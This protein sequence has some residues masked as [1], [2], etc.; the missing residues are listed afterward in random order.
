MKKKLLLLIWFFLTSS[1]SFAWTYPLKYVSKP[2]ASCKFSPWSSLWPDC[3]IPLPKLVPSDYKK[4]LNNLTYR[5]IYTVLRWASYKYWWDQWYGSHE[6]VDIATSLGTPVY[7]IGPGKVVYAGYKKGWW[8]VIVIQHRLNWRYIYSDYAHLSKI[9]VKFW[10][11]VKEWQKIGEVGHTG[12]SI[13]NHL[14]FEID[15]NQSISHHPFW[16]WSCA[17]WRRIISITNDNKCFPELERNTID[18][19]KFLATNWAIV[20]TQTFEKNKIIQKIP[21]KNMIP[22]EEIRKQMIKEF[23]RT[24]K[25]YF[26]FSN[27][28]VYYLGK[29]WYFNI[30]LRDKRWRVYKDILPWDLK[31]IYDRNYFSS[32]YP[33]VIKI[34]DETR[35]VTFLPRKSWATFITVKLWDFTIFQKAIRILKPGETI[36][37]IYWNIISIPTVPYI[38]YP[39]WGIVVFK[40]RSYLNLINTPFK[41]TYYLTS[42][43]KNITFCKAPTNINALNFFHCSVENMWKVIPFTYKN[44]IYWLLVF[45]FFSNSQKPSEI[46]IKD[47]KWRVIVSKKVY[48]QNIKLTDKNSPYAKYV[49][50]ACKMWLCLWLIDKWYIWINKPLSKYDMKNLLRN[51]LLLLWKRVKINL[52]IPEK[53]Q[54]VTRKQFVEYLFALLWVEIKNYNQI[55]KYI[56]IRNEDKKF[57]NEVV[58]LTR[59]WFS[60]KDRFAKYHFQPNKNITVWEALYLTEF[61]LKRYLKSVLK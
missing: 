31:I 57:Q 10:Q 51:M 61:L 58:Y 52:S 9:F 56:D 19:L 47:S 28:W 38:W 11:Y 7:S 55:P 26:N 39:A 29:Y 24:H 22:Y 49:Y 20:L 45:K 59:L 50:N 4:Y 40:D 41:W 12:F 53:F 54:Y 8:K 34:L 15:T 16:Y 44:T 33:R 27:L 6:W 30:S 18:P 14:H 36:Q 37:P 3:K 60:W 43:N 1:S 48:F 32:F 25:F 17:R 35:K 42:N 23:L 5:R 2:I 46:L 13:W 21:R